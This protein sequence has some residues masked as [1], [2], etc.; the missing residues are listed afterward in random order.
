MEDQAAR[1]SL[2]SWATRGA[3]EVGAHLHPWTT[4]PYLD[5]PGLRYNDVQHAYPCQ[6]PDELLREKTVN[7]TLAIEQAFRRRPTSYRAGRFG[8]DSRLA[9]MLADEGYVIDSSVTS[10]CSWRDHAGL[11]GQGGP[12]F[13]RHGLTPFVIDGTGARGLLELPVTVCVTYSCL[14]RWPLLFR[15]YGSLP[16]RAARKHLLSRWLAPQPVWLSPDP[17]YDTRD[18]TAVW[19]RASRAGLSAAVMMFHS[20]ELMPGGSPF[21]PDAPSVHDLLTQ[22]DAFFKSVSDH[23]GSFS[24]LSGLAAE[25]L[26][27]GRT[28][29]RPL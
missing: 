18:L 17:R 11:D 2:H 24:T 7:L 6:L 15:A 23:G 3:A 20:S 8:I 5:R 26:A 1:E 13:S 12:D 16:G 9:R 28:E 14:R 29:V 25:V 27:A 4:P 22:L 10:L 21:R 19:R